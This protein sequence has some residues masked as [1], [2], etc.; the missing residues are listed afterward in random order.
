[1]IR[2]LTILLLIVGREEPAIEG[3]TDA[4]ANNYN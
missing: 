3:C 1:M 4:N 2:R